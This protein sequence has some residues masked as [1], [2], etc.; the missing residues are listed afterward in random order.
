MGIRPG[1]QNTFQS[2]VETCH[3]LVEF[4]VSTIADFEQI[5]SRFAKNPFSFQLCHN[6]SQGNLKVF[7]TVFEEFPPYLGV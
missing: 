2:F 3:N 5:L 4:S 6:Q 1:P 7:C